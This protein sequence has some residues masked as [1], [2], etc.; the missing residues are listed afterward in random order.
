MTGNTESLLTRYREL[1]RLGS[2]ASSSRTMAAV[3]YARR[4]ECSVEYA[5]GLLDAELIRRYDTI[6]PMGVV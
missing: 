1:R 3:E 2:P 4:E 5:R 6:L